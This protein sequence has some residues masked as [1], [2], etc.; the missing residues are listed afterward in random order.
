VLLARL[1]HRLQSTDAPLP[2]RAQRSSLDEKKSVEIASSLALLAM[3]KREM[4]SILR[5]H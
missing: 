5:S 4:A 1:Q 3:T 2:L